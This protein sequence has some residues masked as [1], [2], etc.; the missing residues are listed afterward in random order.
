[1]SGSITEERMFVRLRGGGV[2]RLQSEM[3]LEGHS[4][5]QA[6]QSTHL[7]ASMIAMSSQVI[8]PSGQTSTHAPHATHSDPLI[9]AAISMTSAFETYDGI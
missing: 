4:S 6:P 3:Q 1:M 7:P 2:F 8:A 9:V 5:T